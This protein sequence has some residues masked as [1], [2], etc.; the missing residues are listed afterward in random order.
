MKGRIIIIIFT[1]IIEAIIIFS[2]LNGF[3]IYFNFN[4][5][6]NKNIS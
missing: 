2:Y 6:N 1:L 5:T 3:N 4:N